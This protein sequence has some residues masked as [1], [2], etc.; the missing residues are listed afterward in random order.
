MSKRGNGGVPK[1]AS[2]PRPKPG[3]TR[4]KRSGNGQPRTAKKDTTLLLRKKEVREDISL[5]QQAVQERWPVPIAKR[6]RIIRRLLGIIAKE[7]V[8]V[9]TKKGEVVDAEAPADTNAVLASR[10]LVQMVGQNQ[11]DDFRGEP[12]T[13]VHND[14]RTVINVN[15][16]G[17]TVE[18]PIDPE[19]EKRR[20]RLL[21]LANNL[22][23]TGLV[24]DGV[25]VEPTAASNVDRNEP[26]SASKPAGEGD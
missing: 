9:I 14:H 7:S 8:T 25:R 22:R 19:A 23:A 5:V 16:N 15:G 6:P 18:Q 13:V 10:V 4:H 1:T 3:K 17:A 21:E 11:K 20:S 24:I 26:D 2:R 12:D